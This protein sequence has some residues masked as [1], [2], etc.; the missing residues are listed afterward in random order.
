MFNKI[1]AKIGGILGLVTVGT[2]STLSIACSSLLGSNGKYDSYDD[3]K[4]V[5][6][7]TWSAGGKAIAAL[8]DVVKKYNLSQK[9][10]QG[11]IP[12]VIEHVEGGYGT[13]PA[14]AITKIQSKDNRTLPNLYIDYP[15]AVGQVAPYNMAFDVSDEIK[16][17]WFIDEFVKVN[18]QIAGIKKGK[19]FSVPL[20]KSTEALIL[21][22]PLMN[23]LI[24]ELEKQGAKIEKGDADSTLSKIMSSQPSSE[25]LGAIK[26]QWGSIKKGKKADDIIINNDIFDNY[27]DLF[28]F[29]K[30]TQLMFEAPG[31]PNILGV[32]APS[33]LLYTLAKLKSHNVANK[34]LFSKNEETGYVDFNFLKKGKEESETFKQSYNMIKSLIDAGSVWIGGGGAYGST[35]LQKHQM[36]ISI[37]SSAGLYHAYSSDKIKADLNKK[38]TGFILPINKLKKYNSNNKIISLD[39]GTQID[40]S[41]VS[42]TISQGP[43]FNTIHI[44]DREDQGAKA[45]LKW[46]YKNKTSTIEDPKTKA[47]LTPVDY[48]AKQSSYIVPLKGYLDDQSTIGK[49][50]SGK[51]FDELSGPM[52]GVKA[53]FES[54]K[55]ELKNVEQ[56]KWLASIVSL[57]VDDMTGSIRK[58]IDSN[59]VASLNSHNNGANSYNDQDLWSKMHRQAMIDQIIPSDGTFNKTYHYGNMK[60]RNFSDI[61]WKEFSYVDAKI[62]S[63][64]DGDTPKVE[65]INTSGQDSLKAIKP[66]EHYSIRIQGIDTPEAHVKLGE[67]KYKDSEDKLVG[68]TDEQMKKLIEENKKANHPLAVYAHG[69]YNELS[70]DPTSKYTYWKNIYVDIQTTKDGKAYDPVIKDPRH[71]DSIYDMRTVQ[72]DIGN[73]EKRPLIT[74][75]AKLEGDWGLQAGNLGRQ[76]M[77]AGT[78]IRIATD[79]KKSYNRI[80]GSIFYGENLSKN[81]SVEILKRGLTLPFLS[82]PAAV[83]DE[84]SILY[85]NGKAI[86]DAFNYAMNNKLGIFKITHG[87]SLEEHLKNILSTHGA[88]DY[89]PLIDY[90]QHKS[91]GAPTS[92]YDYMKTRKDNRHLYRDNSERIS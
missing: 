44:N 35:R 13:I 86:A 72:V 51:S 21:D 68:F 41:K 75:S 62:T 56:N 73:G 46:F 77:K 9:D 54:I 39:D 70:T 87:G 36:A 27:E 4:I 60:D 84:T 61:N 29:V 5:I 25:D 42:A 52:L 15:S 12:V 83:L 33:N 59:I 16:R 49:L 58:I 30:K 66:G 48:F 40:Q 1:K 7:T 22:K 37:S 64:I 71:P 43:S 88:T 91:V 82:N 80:V 20:S 10:E 19:M 32:D 76:E 3:N 53:S 85:H 24:T 92:I 74:K 47:Q 67:I 55:R 23:Y 89:S 69:H 34:F 28:A 63:W 65:I 45:F 18:D 6:Q 11:F 78:K 50:V 17:D 14:Q 79:G 81:W 2:M 38:E 31:N 90:G 26:T 8:E 57:P